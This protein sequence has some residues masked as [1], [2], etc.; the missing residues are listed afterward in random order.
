MANR[1]WKNGNALVNAV[2]YQA[3]KPFTIYYSPFTPYGY[4]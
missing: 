1:K 4:N 3:V 2:A